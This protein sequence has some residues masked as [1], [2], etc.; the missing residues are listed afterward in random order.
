MTVKFHPVCAG[1]QSPLL[2]LHVS[3]CDLWLFLKKE[4]VVLLRTSEGMLGLCRVDIGGFIVCGFLEEVKIKAECPYSEMLQNLKHS[5]LPQDTRSKCS[6]DFRL[7]M[8][9]RKVKYGKTLLAP[10]AWIR[11]CGL[12]RASLEREAAWARWTGFCRSH[13]KEEVQSGHTWLLRR[14]GRGEVGMEGSSGV[15]CVWGSCPWWS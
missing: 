4:N 7:G 9:N 12:C 8:L 1:V 5:E 15:R 13:R 10:G 14:A 2:W 3:L 11:T 6:L